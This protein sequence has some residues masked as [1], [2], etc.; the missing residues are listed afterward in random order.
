MDGAA[1]RLYSGRLAEE[2]QAAVMWEFVAKKHEAKAAWLQGQVDEL[3]ARER[4][5]RRRL[6]RIAEHATAARRW[7]RVACI[8][9]GLAV[10]L[11]AGLVIARLM[12][13]GV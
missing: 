5:L 3:Q 8:A 10:G 9:L 11:G 13:G 7:E 2:H 4:V 6:A 1:P 12:G